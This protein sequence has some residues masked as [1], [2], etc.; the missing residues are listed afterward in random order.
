MHRGCWNYNGSEDWWEH[1]L[2]MGSRGRKEGLGRL[3]GALWPP[4]TVI[5]PSLLC[6][7]SLGV[8]SLFLSLPSFLL[9]APMAYG[10][11]WAREVPATYAT[12]AATPDP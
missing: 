3:M 4:V 12:A 5:V 11:S 9:A 10:S 2:L 1:G 8:S 6:A 7:E